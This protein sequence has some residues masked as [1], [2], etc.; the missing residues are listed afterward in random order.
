MGVWAQNLDSLKSAIPGMPEDTHKVQAIRA[1]YRGYYAVGRDSGLLGAA[2]EGLQLSRK[3]NYSKGVE[4]FL[5]YKASALDIAGRGQESI[6]LFEEGLALAQKANKPDLAADFQ[7]NLGTAHQQ[8]GNSDQSLRNYLEAYAYYKQSGQ[9]KNLSKVLNNIGILYRNQEKYERAEAIYRESLQIKQQ[10]NDSLGMATGYQ[11]LASLLSQTQRT[12]EAIELLRQ[13]LGLYET[14]HRNEDVAGCYSLLGQIYFNSNRMQEAKVS[15]QKALEGFGGQ[16][17][18]DYSPTTYHLLGI[19]SARAQNHSE[20]Q[21]YFLTGLAHA[22]EF[23]Q[24]ERQIELLR[25]LSRTQQ[26]LGN[27]TAAFNSLEEAYMLKDSITEQKRLALMEEMQT[28]FEVTQ[29]DNA[30]RIN[31]LELRER[32]R[33]RNAVMAGALLLGILALAIVIGL[34]QRIRANKKI[35]AQERALQQQQIVQLEQESRLNTLKAVMEGQEKERSRIAADLHDGLGGLLTS[36]KSHFNALPYPVQD[37]EMFAKTN[38]L[39]DDACDE[40]RRIAHNMMPRAL[41]VSGLKGALEDLVNDLSKQGLQCRLEMI[42]MSAP[43]PPAMEMMLYRILQEL[44]SNVVKHARASELLIQLLRDDQELTVIVEDNGRGFELD[45]ARNKNGIGLSSI[46]SRVEYLNGVISWD[47]VPGQ[48]T[49]V[50]IH[51]PVR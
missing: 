47:S 8:L 6:P 43:L 2:E 12:D 38:G 49:T 11:N 22:R 3:L 18:V 35:A 28:R 5:F 46:Q 20:A 42:S 17:N 45:Q 41:G 33:E 39:M 40:V 25:E 4:L 10:L 50:S 30:L 19:L 37:Q 51:L 9:L 15:L 23:G 31:Q 21:Q 16:K 26:A 32:T 44:C 1:L 14:L 13:S 48:G 29:K 24:K 34:R 36:V 27:P 7:V